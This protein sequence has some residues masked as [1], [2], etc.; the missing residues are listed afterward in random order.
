MAYPQ[1]TDLNQA[2][3]GPPKARFTGQPYGVAAAQER[4]QDAVPTGP[5]PPI[6]GASPLHS[7][8]ARPGEPVTAGAPVG[9][10]P[11][12]GALG[13][14]AGLAPPPGTA[15]ALAEQVRA[16]YTRYPNANLLALLSELE[17]R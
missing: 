15:D 9:P 13:G 14:P 3:G 5:P 17:G 7:P 11:G 12:P 16:I 8:S 6:P 2:G 10:G 4:A 1:R